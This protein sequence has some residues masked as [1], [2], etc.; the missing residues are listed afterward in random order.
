MILLFYAGVMNLIWIAG[1]AIFIL[2]EKTA[3]AGEW[4][5]MLAGVVLI[6]WGS[7]LLIG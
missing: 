6:A 3:P 5:G 2:I 4:I 7:L 1:L